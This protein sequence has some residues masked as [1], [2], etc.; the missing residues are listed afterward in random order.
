MTRTTKSTLY[1]FLFL[2]AILLITSC[3][4]HPVQEATPFDK[5]HARSAL[6][7][8]PALHQDDLNHDGAADEGT[9]ADQGTTDN[10][11][12]GTD[13]N[14]DT[15]TDGD[16]GHGDSPDITVPNVGA[17]DGD[18]DGNGDGDATGDATGDADGNPGSAGSEASTTDGD[19]DGASGDGGDVDDKSADGEVSAEEGHSDEGASGADGQTVSGQQQSS[20]TDPG[21]TNHTDPGP[22]LTFSFSNETLAF[23]SFKLIQLV[24]SDTAD[25]FHD[26]TIFENG[27]LT[28]T[29]AKSPLKSSLSELDGANDDEW[30]NESVYSDRLSLR[31]TFDP[32]SEE[33]KISK[34][35]ISVAVPSA[36][37]PIIKTFRIEQT[38]DMGFITILYQCNPGAGEKARIG[39]TMQITEKYKFDAS[40]TKSCGKGRFEKLEFGFIAHDE[41]ISYFNE[42][43]T[44]GKEEQKPLEVGPTDTSTALS[45][46]LVPP[47]H[48]LDFMDPVLS[49]DSEDVVVSLRGTVAKGTL[50]SDTDT[51]FSILYECKAT[52][53]AKISFTVGI[54]P[55]ENVTATW[56]KDCGGSRS[57]ALLIGTSGVDSYEV[58]QDGELSSRYNVTESTQLDDVTGSIEEI[59]G[60]ADSKR[61]YLTNSDLTSDVQ[62]QTIS[63]TMSNPD[64]LTTL[65]KTPSFTSG[66]FIPARGDTLQREET[67]SLYLHFI[68]K[69]AGKSLVLITLPVLRYKNIEFGFIK[70]CFEPKIYHHSGFLQTAG[71]IMGSLIALFVLAGIGSLICMRRRAGGAK[72]SPV[73][74]NDSGLP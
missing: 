58:M 40:W 42:D 30:F 26:E 74:T 28:G 14:T 31:F 27:N 37:D 47:A 65:V 1:P 63:T 66:S 70:E 33:Y 60:D 43:G 18:S 19:A 2:G 21:T 57:Q 56:R 4:T 49:S 36:I 45:M 6:P 44:Y 12:P 68:C 7:N 22:G 52:T 51:K 61:F 50:Q 24:E 59:P 38:N 67:K 41:S 64:V 23:R 9:G 72:Y 34:P 71:S 54:P 32:D 25:A 69:Q 55:W 3:T 39:M 10:P 13:P 8:K 16:E 29:F 62:I 17:P 15:Q 5:L 73:S 11:D 46:K 48:T 20:S 35:M 53:K